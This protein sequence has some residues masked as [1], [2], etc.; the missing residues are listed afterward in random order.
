MNNFIRRF[1]NEYVLY[2]FLILSSADAAIFLNNKIYLIIAFIYTLF[3]YLKKYQNIENPIIIFLLFWIVI[4]LIAY[5]KFGNVVDVQ[6]ITFLSLTSRLLLP[7]FILR[8]YRND[9]IYTIETL[10]YYLTLISLPIFVVQYLNSSLFYSLS[11]LLN[12]LTGEEQREFGGWYI[13]VYMFSGWAP[14]RNSGFMFEPGAFAFM[15]ILG[16]LIRFAK[17]RM[18]IDRY[19]IVYIIGIITTFSTMGYSVLILI[20]LTIILRTG[21]ISIYIVLIPVFIFSIFTNILNL[22]FML[23][24]IQDYAYEARTIS[25]SA[26]SSGG[27]LR[28]NRFGIFLFAID[29]S[30]KWP[31]GYGVLDGTPSEVQF[32]ERI[33]GPNTFAQILLR[34]GW[35][36]L[37]LYIIAAKR[38]MDRLYPHITVLARLTLLLAFLASVSSYSMLNNT[39]LL[40]ILYYP[41][42]TQENINLISSRQKARIKL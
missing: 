8:L 35:L 20:I 34:W 39:V 3:L 10:I 36:G 33:Q 2:I 22:D 37:I 28:Y 12:I 32:N 27:V 11:P 26:E 14:D 19:I 21:R 16:I 31:F 5:L 17:N 13:G 42:I 6:F 29:E 4:N 18:R 23:P 1:F 24:K 30:I 15:I 25:R 7:Y 40:A 38:A 9:F 41:F